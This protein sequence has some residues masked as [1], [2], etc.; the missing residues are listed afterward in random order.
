V[1]AFLSLRGQIVGLIGAH[2]ILP[3]GDFLQAVQSE[4][5]SEGYHLF[6]TLAWISSSDA[7]LKL[8]CSAGALLGVLVILG[9]VT[10]PALVLAW[11]CY[12]SLVTVGQ[13]FLSYQWDILLLETGFLAIFF[14]PWNPLEPPWRAGSSS[15]STTV[16]WLGRWLVFRL[17]FLSGAVKLLSGDPTWRNLTAL[18]YHYWT[19]PLPIPVAWYAAQLPAWFQKTS[20]VGVFTIE[21]AVPFLIFTPRRFRRIGAG[22]I[23]GLQLLIVLTGNYGFFNLLT[24]FLCIL[25]LDDSLI[26]RWLPTRLVNR[27][28]VRTSAERYSS[29]AAP[30]GKVIRAVLAVLILMISGSEMLQTFG[31]GLRCRA[32]RVNWL[33]GRR[34]SI[35]PIP[36]A[37]LPS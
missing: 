4:F 18:E 2:G 23:V 26:S 10:G 35:L 34:L 9:V 27:L 5:G 16:V 29:P 25:L 19:Q 20:V 17:M 3:V 31:R 37:C 1:I 7:S 11:A 24:I 6:P 30:A 32:L 21:L 12:L 33:V 15:V 28:T 8:L 22:L 13:E 14:A 36:T